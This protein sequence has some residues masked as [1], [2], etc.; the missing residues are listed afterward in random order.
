[1]CKDKIS[2]VDARYFGANINYETM[3]ESM[4]NAKLDEILYETVLNDVISEQNVNILTSID[5][6]E[7][8]ECHCNP[9]SHH[10]VKQEFISS[11]RV[12]AVNEN[13]DCKSCQYRHKQ[14]TQEYCYDCVCLKWAKERF[15]PE[16][17]KNVP[18]RPV[19]SRLNNGKQQAT[20]H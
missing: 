18:T 2:D 19:R 3:Q 20:A 4:G 17:V 1:M 10:T 14:I 5:V 11:G 12:P 13:I 9:H 6:K 16:S 15:S 7:C 8:F